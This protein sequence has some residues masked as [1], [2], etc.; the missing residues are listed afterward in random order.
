MADACGCLA[1]MLSS[2]FSSE[3]SLIG[4]DILIWLLTEREGY[5]VVIG[6]V[7]VCTVVPASDALT[8]LTLVYHIISPSSEVC[9]PMGL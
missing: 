9:R 3:S 7:T 4:M 2:T 5:G 1:A 6:V 8:K